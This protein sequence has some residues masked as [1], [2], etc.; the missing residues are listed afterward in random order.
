M[1]DAVIAFFALP[2]QM[3]F[4]GIFIIVLVGERLGY[5]MWRIWHG[6]STDAPNDMAMVLTS[7]F[8]LLSLLLAFTFSMAANRFEERRMLV[9]SEA[10]AIGTAH[11][12]TALT[13]DPSGTDLRLALEEYA[14]IRLEFGTLSG[15]S[16][17]AAMERSVTVRD[18]LAA[19]ALAASAAVRSPPMGPALLDS[20]NTVIDVGS[21]RD[22]LSR[23]SVPYTIACLLILLAFAAAVL[24][25]AN[26]TD[27]GRLPSFSNMFLLLLLALSMTLIADLDR[28]TSGNIKVSQYPMEELIEGFDAPAPPQGQALPGSEPSPST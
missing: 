18:G 4:G 26:S 28:P 25:G 16:R 21:E 6:G 5:W 9:I 14:R 24:L 3:L 11:I 27:K 8:G 20:V 2:L 10:N 13:D 22:A 15:E 7:V 19:K 17:W 23:T 12:R 1:E